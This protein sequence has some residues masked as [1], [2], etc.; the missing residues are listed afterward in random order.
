MPWEFYRW[1]V[2]ER[3]GWTLEYVDSLKMEDLHEH[4]QIEDGIS[5]ANKSLLNKDTNVSNR[6][7]R[8]RNRR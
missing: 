1:K 3:F 6:D 7:S 4:F 8:S 5:K 2:A